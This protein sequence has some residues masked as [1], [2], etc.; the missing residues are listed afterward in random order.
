M[1]YKKKKFLEYSLKSNITNNKKIRQQLIY[2]LI[3]Q[4]IA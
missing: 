4:A 1:K 3:K 2:L